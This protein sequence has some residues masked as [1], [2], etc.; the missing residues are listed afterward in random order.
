[1]FRI[2]GGLYA[3]GCV[4][5]TPSSAKGRIHNHEAHLGALKPVGQHGVLEA[6]ILRILTLNHH[7]R[8]ADGVGLRIDFLP[9]EPHVC[10]GIIPLDKIV[11]SGQ[12]TT[13]STGLVEYGDNLP[14]IEDVIAA[15]CQ[16]DIHHELDDV[17]ARVVVASLGIFREL[18]D[19]LLENVPHLHIVDG[20][21]V[22]VKLRERLDH[23]E[24]AIVLVHLINL[25][26]EVEAADNVL[27]I[28]REA[29]YV[30]FKVRG[31]MLGI[32]HQLRKV[33]AA[34]VI[35]LVPGH[36]VHGLCG[37][38]RIGGEGLQHLFLGWGQRTLEAPD[39]DHRDDDI[40]VFVTLVCTAQFVCNR[41]D[42]VY[43][44]GNVNGRVIPHGVYRQFLCHIF[45]PPFVGMVSPQLTS[46]VKLYVSNKMDLFRFC[47]I[48]VG[49]F[50]CPYV[51]VRMKCS[52]Q[53]T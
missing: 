28:G 34:G 3:F 37:I 10:G 45:F 53:V 35:E 43:L 46:I 19:E 4:L 15:F 20:A 21:R 1:M 39:N 51:I 32:V 42:E 2:D 26:V 6:D 50:R 7:L 36:P 22:E 27:N 24:Q 13:R 48:V 23:A 18:P 33:K 8:K 31:Q 30:G 25:L 47:L 12:H 17:A 38:I 41:P 40:L 9:E 52:I 49:K 5:A 29:L 44:C 16:Q 14:V 11:R